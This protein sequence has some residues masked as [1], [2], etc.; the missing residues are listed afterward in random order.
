MTLFGP[1]GRAAV[2]VFV[3]LCGVLAAPDA[4]ADGDRRWVSGRFH[5]GVSGLHGEHAPDD[6]IPSIAWASGIGFEFG[7]RRRVALRA[8]VGSL[9]LSTNRDAGTGR[10]D[11][12]WT[13]QY[14][15]VAVGPRLRIG[16]H[17]E[18]HVTLV[19]AIR[20]GARVGQDL[21][22]GE[23]TAS[24]LDVD[25]SA[26][27]VS[28]SLECAVRWR[29]RGGHMDVV[30][31]GIQMINVADRD[32]DATRMRWRT[33]TLGVGFWMRPWAAGQED[34]TRSP[35]PPLQPPSANQW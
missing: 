8:D 7:P 10:R 28:A 32:E 12:R 25:G 2:S 4:Y 26:A 31:T 20:G 23:I 15:D 5:L 11:G 33:V 9:Y 24:T 22:V 13:V 3:F 1:L 17:R 35:P 21:F 29:V 27:T 34:P 18:M 14:L 6:G 30:L 19:P 16:S